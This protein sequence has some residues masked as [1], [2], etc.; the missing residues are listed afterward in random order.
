MVFLWLSVFF[1]MEVYSPCNFFPHLLFPGIP[2]HLQSRR[3]SVCTVARAEKYFN[4]ASIFIFFTARVRSTTEGH[5]FTLLVCS[6]GGGGGCQVSPAGGGG[7]Q[8]QLP[9]GG[10]SGPAAGGVGQVQLLGR[11]GSG[12]AAGEGGQVQLPGGGQSS[13]Q[14]GVSQQGEGGSASC[15]LLRA[16]C[17]LRSRRRTFLFFTAR[18]RSTTGR[19]CFDTCLSVCPQG[20]GV[21]WPTQPEGRVR[22]SSQGGGQVQLTGGGGQIRSSRGGE[23]RSS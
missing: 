1:I 18:V 14:G 22:S 20:G 19:L 6:R 3:T 12:P 16:V 21:S 17:L 15:A 23:V 7:G 5:S 8:V 10:G 4:T 13:R 9:G 11:G 2:D